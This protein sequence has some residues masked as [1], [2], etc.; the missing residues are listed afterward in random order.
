MHV[1]KYY[2]PHRGGMESHLETLC[3]GL[4]DHVTLQVVVASGRAQ[5]VV[6][7]VNGVSVDR[8][9]TPLTVVGTP[10]CRGL[11]EA[12]KRADADIV[13]IHLPH[14]GAM[15]AYLASGHRGP[16]VY[17]YHSDIIRQTVSFAV[18]RPLLDT[19]LARA[20][21]IIATSPNYVDSSPVLRRFR[22]LCRVVPL[23]IPIEPYDRGDPDEIAG[24]RARYGDKLIIAVGRQVYY[25]GFEYL[26]RAMEKV[27]GRLLLIGSGPLRPH[28]EKAARDAG[29]TDRVVFLGEIPDLVPFYHAADVFV[30]PA[31]ARSEAF[32]IV[33]LEAMACR[34]PV[35]NTALDSGVPYVSVDGM[36]GL[37]VEPANSEALAGALRRLLGDR[38]LRIR[39]GEAGR[40]RVEAEFTERVMVSRTLQVYRDL[41][42]R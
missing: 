29:V 42:R 39:F 15:V 20:S 18:L 22:S 8:L 41:Q 35:I 19:A 25:K 23:G 38:E 2:P 13:H 6:E 33:Q 36:T 27:D 1:G 5:R 28:L 32:G 26:I 11:V 3:Q 21:A 34:K 7:N 4:K 24:I 37:C 12:I 31:I 14:P 10:L 40:R 30:L 16:L 17:T 9:S